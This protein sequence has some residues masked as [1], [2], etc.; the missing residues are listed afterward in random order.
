MILLAIVIALLTAAA[1]LF[2]AMWRKDHALL[3]L[4]GLSIAIVASAVVVVYAV[5]ENA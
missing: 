1:G 4:A 5:V 2:V 3:G